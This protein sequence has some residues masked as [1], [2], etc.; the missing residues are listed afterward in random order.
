MLSLQKFSFQFQREIQIVDVELDGVAI[1]LREA[2]IG[3]EANIKLASRLR[4][5]PLFLK[6]YSGL[7]IPNG[8]KEQ[9]Q[10]LEIKEEF[11]IT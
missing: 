2:E 9:Q 11:S 4:N 10:H 1:Y 3:R 6:P 7:G 5:V 8:T